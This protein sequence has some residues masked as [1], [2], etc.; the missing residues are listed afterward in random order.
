MKNSQENPKNSQE[1]PCLC[2]VNISCAQSIIDVSNIPKKKK[3]TISIASHQCFFT[4]PNTYHLYFSMI[5]S[6]I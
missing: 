6:L 5:F 4:I 2:N 3:K 1:N